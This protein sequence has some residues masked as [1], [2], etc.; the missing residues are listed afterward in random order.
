MRTNDLKLGNPVQLQYAL[1]TRLDRSI[2]FAFPMSLHS[3]HFGN[4]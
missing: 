3:N 1:E 4:P 2:L